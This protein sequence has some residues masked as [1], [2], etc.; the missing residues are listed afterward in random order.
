MNNSQI[1]FENKLITDSLQ[2]ISASLL[3]LIS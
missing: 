2:E 3:L 1:W